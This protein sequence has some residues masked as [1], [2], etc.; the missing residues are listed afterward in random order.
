[1]RVKT[2]VEVNACVDD[3]SPLAVGALFGWWRL[4]LL[5]VILSDAAAAVTF[6]GDRTAFTTRLVTVATE[7]FKRRNRE[8][9]QA[10]WSR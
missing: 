8:R 10:A 7:D 5:V 4:G 1:V 6:T 9:W 2:G 3:A